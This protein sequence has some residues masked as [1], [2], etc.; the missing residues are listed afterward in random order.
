MK[1]QLK[2]YL[3]IVILCFYNIM[4]DIVLLRE[5]HIELRN[6][7]RK[8]LYDSIIKGCKY[9]LE[10]EY[11][12]TFIDYSIGYQYTWFNDKH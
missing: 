10:K 12:N 7:E 2:N 5:Y 3:L 6:K 9:I 4:L 8:E 11:Y 1:V